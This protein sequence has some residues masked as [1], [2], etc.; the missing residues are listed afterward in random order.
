M[1]YSTE[2]KKFMTE[3]YFRNVCKVNDE[4]SYSVQH[5][6]QECQVQFPQ[7]VVGYKQDPEC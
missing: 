7:V 2:H 4:R 3:S 1:I 5:C 6:L